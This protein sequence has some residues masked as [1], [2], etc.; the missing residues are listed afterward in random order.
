LSKQP[1][2]VRLQFLPVSSVSLSLRVSPSETRRGAQA[3]QEN[4]AGMAALWHTLKHRVKLCHGLSHSVMVYRTLSWFISRCHGLSYSVMVY[5]TLSWFNPLCHGLSHSV[6]VYR[7]LSW[8]I[9]LCHGL[10]HSVIVDAYYCGACWHTGLNHHVQRQRVLGEGCI[11]RLCN[12]TSWGQGVIGMIAVLFDS[13]SMDLFTLT[14]C[15]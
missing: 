13:G 8:F 2:K 6:M 9:A 1:E 7:T 4:K 10:S 3:A 15:S 11:R 5:R 14:C 12:C